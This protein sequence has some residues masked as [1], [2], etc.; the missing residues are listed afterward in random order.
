MGGTFAMVMMLQAID[1]P[2]ASW[3]ASVGVRVSA[4]KRT[5]APSF[6]CLAQFVAIKEE[7]KEGKYPG[8]NGL[9]L[10]YSV[11]RRVEIAYGILADEPS[12]TPRKQVSYKPHG[13]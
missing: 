10:S 4:K 6:Q 9:V 3:I 11:R 7:K 5:P 2:T 8:Q 12:R 1:Q 13:A